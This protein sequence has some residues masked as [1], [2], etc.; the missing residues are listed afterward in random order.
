MHAVANTP[1]G[2]MELVRSYRS[3][4]FGLPSI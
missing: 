2:L 4:S 1:T 3:T